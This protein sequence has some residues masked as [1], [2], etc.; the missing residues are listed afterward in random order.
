MISH[1]RTLAPTELYL[2]N[3]ILIIHSIGLIDSIILSIKGFGEYIVVVAIVSFI[4][5]ACLASVAMALIFCFAMEYCE[6]WSDGCQLVKESICL[7]NDELFDGGI[8]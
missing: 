4:M 7:A 6:S 2:S 5:V 8:F 1:P 3:V